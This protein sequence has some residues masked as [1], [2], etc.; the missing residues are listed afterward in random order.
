MHAIKPKGRSVIGRHSRGPWGSGVSNRG[1][2]LMLQAILNMYC[3]T[4]LLGCAVVEDVR[5]DSSSSRT[6]ALGISEP[7]SLTPG[8]HGHVLKVTGLGFAGTSQETTFGF[9]N[10]TEV[11]LD[12][13]CQV[14]LV[15]S[16][17]EQLQRFAKVVGNVRNICTDVVPI[18]GK[19]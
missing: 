1:F 15:G 13:R 18:G 9:Y 6:I 7:S 11:A 10:I 19:R 8:G 3:S 5:A 4:V 12:P 2:C 17:D 14:V 16:T